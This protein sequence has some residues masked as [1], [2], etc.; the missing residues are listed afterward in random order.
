MA[1]LKTDSNVYD[2]IIVGSGAGGGMAAFRLTAAGANC[3]MLEAG[4]WFDAGTQSRWGHWYYDAPHRGAVPGVAR[5]GPQPPS[6][7]ARG[8]VR[9]REPHRSTGA[10]SPRASTML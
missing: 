9:S 5:E 8:S 1:N 3:L 2:A 7:C 6:P 4:D 10:A